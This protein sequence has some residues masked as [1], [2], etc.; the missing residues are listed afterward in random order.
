MAHTIPI[1]NGIITE[2]TLRKYAPSKEEE[3]DKL[4]ELQKRVKK[5]SKAEMIDHISYPYHYEEH[6][7]RV[8]HLLGENWQ[9]ASKAKLAD[10]LVSHPDAI[11]IL[12]KIY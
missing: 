8:K 2:E 12:K 3:E 11:S 6:I 1:M 7:I 10:Y 4:A 5:M 9:S